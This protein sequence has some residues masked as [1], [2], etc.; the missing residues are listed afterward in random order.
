MAD[1]KENP[2]KYSK[3]SQTDLMSSKR[4]TKSLPSNFFEKVLELEIKLKRAFNMAVLQELVNY[5]SV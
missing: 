3:N 5:Y 2:R 4:T 1:R